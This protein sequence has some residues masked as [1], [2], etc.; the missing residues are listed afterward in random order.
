METLKINSTNKRPEIPR[1]GIR[2]LD[3]VRLCPIYQTMLDNAALS[4]L[5]SAPW[6]NRKQ[7]ELR[8]LLA[9]AQISGRMEVKEIDIRESLRA[10][11]LLEV[12]VPQIPDQS[13]QLQITNEAIIG[14]IYREEALERPQP[15]YSFIQILAPRH[16]WHANV[17]PIE[18]GQ[19]LCLGP[20]LP[21]AIPVKEIVLMTYGAVSMQTVMID[22]RDSAGVLN[23]DASRWWQLNLK[24]IPLTS[25]PFIR[26]V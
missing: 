6:R 21:A 1:G 9:L 11:L 3:H 2:A 7:A 4:C 10:I 24:K 8:E 17:G 23:P 5:G 20:Y 13:G 18:R 15:G 25:E 19:P 14:L 22:E 26:I 16:I 12:P